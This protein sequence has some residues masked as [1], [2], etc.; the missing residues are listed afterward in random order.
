MYIYTH[1]TSW[2]QPA[3]F[4][5]RV[6]LCKRESCQVALFFFGVVLFSFGFAMVSL[7]FYL[8]LL[9]IYSVLLCLPLVLGCCFVLALLTFGVGSYCVLLVSIWFRLVFIECCVVFHWCYLCLFCLL[10]LN[11]FSRVS[12]VSALFPR[13]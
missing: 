8:V 11:C 9:C 1:M 4:I 6:Q 3:A 10:V 12:F 2:R 13:F 7:W 5:Q